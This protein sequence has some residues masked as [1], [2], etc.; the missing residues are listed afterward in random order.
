MELGRGVGTNLGDPYDLLST[1]GEEEDGDE[2]KEEE[3]G[4]EANASGGDELTEFDFQDVEW[5]DDEFDNRD[6]I[7]NLNALLEII[8]RDLASAEQEASIIKDIQSDTSV[9]SRLTSISD[10][11]KTLKEKISRDISARVSAADG[12]RLEAEKRVAEFEEIIN[13]NTGNQKN[14]LLKELRNKIEQF[15]NSMEVEL[16]SKEAEIRSRHASLGDD[17]DDELQ[18]ELDQAR[19]EMQ[20]ELSSREYS[21]K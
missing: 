13:E 16:G 7:R 14:R 11:V 2:S 3:A 9:K 17:D 4:A 8:E 12:I 5:W 19:S 20:K 6:N 15:R 10:D 1:T 18:K 21:L